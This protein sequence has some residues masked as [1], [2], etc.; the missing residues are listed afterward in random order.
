VYFEATLI[1]IFVYIFF[2][3]TK[4]AFEQVVR[5]NL[6]D[7]TEP[8]QPQI[9]IIGSIQQN[10]CAIQEII[11]GLN[12]WYASSTILPWNLI[13]KEAFNI[14]AQKESGALKV[15]H[16]SMNNITSR[17]IEDSTF[18]PKAFCQDFRKKKPSAFL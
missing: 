17:H 4:T 1:Y 12:C 3:Q 7:S 14:A 11:C 10:K 8:I 6:K 15:L 16:N 9:G 18:N 5:L 2:P 13:Q